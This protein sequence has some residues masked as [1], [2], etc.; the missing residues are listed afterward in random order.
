MSDFLITSADLI[1][2]RTIP[3]VISVL[4]V[5]L[6]L[7]GC[8]GGAASDIVPK[9]PINN[10][11]QVVFAEDDWPGWRGG[12][13]QGI[14]TGPAAPTK[15]SDKENLIWSAEIPGRGHSSPVVIGNQIYLTSADETRRTQNVICLQRKTGNQAWM[16]RVHAGGL[17]SYAHYKNTQ[18][19]PSVVCDLERVFAL[20]MFDS[21]VQLSALDL[22]GKLLWTTI[23]GPYRSKYGYSPSPLL[24]GPLV[25]IAADHEGG[26][27]L[28]GV[29]RYTGDIHWRTSRPPVDSYGTPAIHKV[30]GKDTLFIAG[31]GELTAYEPLTGK[32]LW[33]IKGLTE[34][35]VGSP[36]ESNQT[37]LASGGYPGN[38]TLAVKIMENSQPVVSWRSSTKSYVPSLLAHEG[39]LFQVTDGG[40]GSCWDVGTGEMYW[41]ARLGGDFSS[42]P[43]LSGEH[44][45]VSN[46]AGV[47]Q[48]FK[49]SKEKFQ[50]VSRNKLGDEQMAS[51]AICGGRIYIRAASQLEGGKRVEMLYCIGEGGMGKKGAGEP[52]EVKT[53]GEVLNPESPATDQDGKAPEQAPK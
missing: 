36:V 2:N 13:H 40:N 41:Q 23:V 53:E 51:P 25:I 48:V 4:L 3:K 24:Y 47:T 30:A 10:T 5:F 28:A 46:E 20:F 43:V 6:S 49:A 31:G 45:Y 34:A 32:R 11:K 27:Y 35:C 1:S 39:L 22:T 37:I 7:S 38:E 14:A 50:L 9:W 29:N 42:S 21:R 12:S 18:A 16:T 44:V 19:T 52:V 8:G 15:W 17:D 26:G 33:G